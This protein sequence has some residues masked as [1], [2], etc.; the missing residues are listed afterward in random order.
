MGTLRFELRKDKKNKD[1]RAPIR[2]IYQIEGNRRYYPTGEKTFEENWDDKDQECVYYKIDRNG[3]KAKGKLMEV[4]VKKLNDRLTDLRRDIEKIE[5]RFQAN[6]TSYTPDAVIK[7]LYSLKN[8]VAKKDA[9]SKELFAFIDEY[10]LANSK[11]RVK[12]SLSVY[13][14]LKSH[15]QDFEKT[16]HKKVT[17]DK[18]DYKFFE[19]FENYLMGLK[20]IIVL[21]D[22]DGNRL[23]RSVSKLN[24]ITIAKQLST[25]KTFLSY[26]RKRK[27]EVSTEYQTYKIE[28]DTELE[29]V[30]LTRHE[31]ERLYSI[32]LKESWDQVRDVFCF[33]CV[34]GLRYSD[35]KKLTRENIKGNWIYI[36]VKKT[37]KQLKIPLNPYSRN[38]LEKYK[39]ELRPLPVISNQRS[40]EHLEKI[41]K[42]AGLN[43]MIPVDRMYGA[44]LVSEKYPKY[45]LIRMHAGRKTFAT[46]SLEKGMGAQTVMALGGWKDFKSFR[47]YVDHSDESLQHAMD[48]AWGAKVVKPKLQAV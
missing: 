46:L 4:D 3:K 26:A 8:P 45:Q 31:F 5:D 30:A 20:K 18:I 39:N 21:K 13:K 6:E 42:Y 34:T 15:L 27:I 43:E 33:S 29:V 24:N 16:T 9:T 14:S 40:N 35:L 28:R 2:I 10:I 36:K 48:Q 7:E 11:K 12:G 22:E 17:F 44:E 32:P 38:I 37:K 47:R 1:G 41:C 23:E 19:S 25:L